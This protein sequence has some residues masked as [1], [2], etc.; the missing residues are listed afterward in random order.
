MINVLIIL[1]IQMIFFCI[2]MLI[3]LTLFRKE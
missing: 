1:A 3:G 2:V